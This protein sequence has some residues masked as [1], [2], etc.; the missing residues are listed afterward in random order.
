MG[1]KDTPPP[2]C[3][4]SSLVQSPRWESNTL[5]RTRVSYHN[6]PLRCKSEVNLQP[7]SMQRQQQCEAPALWN[8]AP[9][10]PEQESRS[11]QYTSRS[12]TG[13]RSDGTVSPIRQYMECIEPQSLSCAI[14]GDS[15][16]G[17]SSLL[18][19]YTKGEMPEYQA[20]TVYDKFSSEW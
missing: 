8:C 6:V 7:T 13:S 14:V 11:S 3:S 1:G 20:P 18:L 4:P 16:V 17:K 5:G 15:G 9:S 2:E 12:S 19:S 10:S